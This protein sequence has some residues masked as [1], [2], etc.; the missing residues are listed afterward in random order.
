MSDWRYFNLERL[1]SL[2]QEQGPREYVW[3]FLREAISL[4]SCN[5][6]MLSIISR[7]KLPGGLAC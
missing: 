2:L 5:K 7:S 6:S 3:L 1:I 4:T